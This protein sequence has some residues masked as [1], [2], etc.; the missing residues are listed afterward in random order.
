MSA[1]LPTI[2][3]CRLY[4]LRPVLLWLLW[5]RTDWLPADPVEAGV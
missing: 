3:L 2:A 1:M 5:L 4:M